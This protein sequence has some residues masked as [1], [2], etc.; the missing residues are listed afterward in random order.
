MILQHVNDIAAICAAHGIT[1]A[2]ISPGS[3]SAAVTLAFDKHPDIN[4]HVITDERSAAFIAMGIAQQ[5]QRPAVLICT[6][7]SAGL[8]YA[9]AVAEAY[10]QEIPLIVL[11]ADRPPEWIDQYDGQTI[12]Q[13][14]MFGNHVKASFELPINPD[15]KDSKWQSNRIVNEAIIKSFDDTNGPVH[16]NIPIREPFYPDREEEISF[17]NDLRI[18]QKPSIEKRLSAERIGT[19][20]N[21]WNNSANRWIV[22]GQNKPDEDLAK[23]LELLGQSVVIINE[24]TANQHAVK[25]AIQNQDALFSPNETESIKAPELLI[26]FGNSLISKN[27]KLF[28]RENP[29]KTHWHIND[30]SRMNDSLQSLSEMIQMAPSSF[31]NDLIPHVNLDSKSSLLSQLEEKFEKKKNTFLLTVSFGEFKAVHKVMDSLPENVILHLANSMSVRYANFVGGLKEG[32]E[33]YCNRGTS[34]IDGSNS[35]AIGATIAT[36]RLNLLITGDLAFFYDRN[37]FWNNEDYSNL[38]VVI[39]NNDGGGIFNMIPGPKAQTNTEKLFLTPH[40]LKA[41]HLAEEFDLTYYPVHTEAELN[42]RLKNFFDPSDKAQIIEV[43][44]DIPMNT[45]ILDQFKSI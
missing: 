18:I 31:L 10:Y 42:E 34:G 4:T 24:I 13:S 36:N 35:T 37:A 40:G 17:S 9:P 21:T 26:T 23:A 28:L 41:F 15:H 6:S 20:S 19:L 33:V 12:I 8:N 25:G 38:R 1:D 44:S 39:L 16:I 43:F 45:E 30:S 22:I 2:V 14:G 5:Q 29:P 7:G 3:R 27:L 11:T 32:I